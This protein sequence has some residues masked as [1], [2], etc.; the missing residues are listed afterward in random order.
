MY[1]IDVDFQV[2]QISSFKSHWSQGYLIPKC[3]A[4]MCTF[5]LDSNLKAASQCSQKY[6]SGP[7]TD[8]LCPLKLFIVAVSKSHSSH[9]YGLSFSLKLTSFNSEL[10]PISTSSLTII[11]SFSQSSIFLLVKFLV[12]QFKESF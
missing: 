7:C 6:L 4:S 8:F 3:F 12:T 1:C 5:N 10:S 9:L 2:F 11:S